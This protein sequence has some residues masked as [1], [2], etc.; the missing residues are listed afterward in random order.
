MRTAYR[1]ILTEVEIEI[2]EKKSRFIANV[3]NAASEEEAAAFLETIR[4]KYWDARHNVYAYIIGGDSTI[5]KC[6]DD[7]EPAGTAGVPVLE[8]IKKEGIEDVVIVVTRYF[9]GIL[10]GTGGLVRAYSRCAREGIKAARTG[11]K[12]LCAKLNFRLDYSQLGRMQNLSAENGYRIIDVEYADAVNVDIAIP[13]GELGRFQKLLS[14][15]MS[16]SMDMNEIDKDY[17]IIEED[18]V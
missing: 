14:E 16:G 12:I 3:R 11:K 15:A 10:L 7:G 8:T 2:T 9:G 17:Y 1:T 6:S 18:N 4:K 13:V 5:Q